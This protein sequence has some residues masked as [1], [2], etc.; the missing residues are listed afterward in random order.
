MAT[1]DRRLL[2]AAT[3]GDVAS[4]KHL[5]S[6]EPG[7]LFGTT[8]PGNTCLHISSVQ[9]HHEFCESILAL[10]Q[11][12]ALL[13]AVNK[14]GETPLLA[15]VARGRAS[16]ASALLRRCRERQLRE[17]MLKQDR[18][19]CNALHHAV[20]RGHTELALELVEAEPA[21]STAVNGRSE[22]PL[23]LAAMRNFTEV[24]DKL[25]DVPDSAHSG[26]CG[27]NVLHAAVRSGNLAIAKRVMET[28]LWLA[29]EENEKKHTPVHLAAYEGEINALAVLLEHDPCLGYLTSTNGDPLLCVAASQGHGGVARELLEHCP[30]APYC[31][32]SGSTCLHI[33]VLSGH[34]EFVRS[35]LGF[36][37]LGH[38]INMLN[39]SGETALHLAA[40]NCKPDMVA[41]L[42][43][44][45]DI[46]VTVLNSDGET[47][48]QV[49]PDAAN[50][51]KPLIS[52]TAHETETQAAAI[53]TSSDE[54]TMTDSSSSGATTTPPPPPVS[55]P[56]IQQRLLGAAVCGNSAE[57]KHM[58][59]Q[60]PGV[61][62][63]ATPQ[64]NTCLHIAC[65]HGHERFCSD[66]LALTDHQST[67]TL[68]GAVNAD[69]ETP[70]LA[71]VTSGHV[72]LAS[73]ILRCCRDAQLSEAILTQDKRGFNALH[74]A[75]R[76]RHR[77][78]A[79]ELIDTEPGLS[80]AVNKY[81]ESPMFIAV[82][83]N[84]ADVSEKLL[85]EIPDSAHGGAYGYNALHAA[86]RCGNPV[87]AK[88]ILETRPGLAREEDK[89][90]ATPM[91]MAVHWDQTDVLRV[92][93]EHD[94]TLG[95]VLDSKGRPI[96]GSAAS[97][98]Y[99]GAARE[100]LKHC[101]D[102]PYGDGETTCLHQAVQGGHIE[103]LEFFLGSKH[104]GKLVNMRD[105]LQETPLHDAVRS[106]NPKIVDALLLHP[107][108]DVTMLNFSGNPATWVL[109]DEEAKT[110][111]WN[112]ISMRMLKADPDA[113][114]DTYN[115]YKQ[116]KD[117]VTS[118]SKKDIKELTQTYTSNTSLVAILI[119]TITFAAAFTL[120]GGYSN[121]AGS[122]GLP[123]MTRKVAF[124]AFLIS[125]SLA[126]FSSL[127][128][129]FIS[130]MARWEDFEFLLYYRS[131]TKRLMWVGY[132]ATTIAFATGLYTI[133]APRLLWLAITICLMSVL[134]PILTWLLGEWHVLKLRFHLGETFKSEFLDMV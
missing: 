25:L 100:L 22:S 92:L 16:L 2:K 19:G 23:F 87:I 70:L 105:A 110:L 72:S 6:Q 58:A 13:S 130:I 79:L 103:L 42:Q 45:Q 29:R 47:A 38:L 55:L 59:L 94:W 9:G 36:Q 68:L 122:E 20:S 121:D 75:I 5:A 15:A 85:V 53:T 116:T 48:S 7:V 117:K 126:M 17:A 115:L 1:M 112:E 28:R 69:G 40:R 18:H 109:P 134:L 73:F 80:K 102:A 46:N 12:P 39:G 98:G 10:D 4:L 37:Q 90:K 32:A 34:T 26:A 120:P 89:H 83:R 50:H 71:A 67:A 106:C 95:Y 14:D 104:L 113:A 127:A 101:P 35:I 108:T 11:S 88:R 125:D 3:S 84:Y 21:L 64:G 107:D 33:A 57:M 65:T 81:G 131:F 114:N 123:I 129:A 86:V 44:H 24:S 41:A 61:L 133:L 76:S 78:L 62:L 91:H 118:E 74:H 66:V 132:I 60:T 77:K 96:L 43:H 27:F 97:R 54:A 31:D 93:L 99:V 49:L 56:I 128:V 8:P 82:M 124:Q 30:D 63:G 111:N 51:T 119:A 52:T